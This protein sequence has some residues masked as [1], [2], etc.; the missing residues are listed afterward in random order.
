MT[1]EQIDTLGG[2]L[3]AALCAILSPYLDLL[4]EPTRTNAGTFVDVEAQL[5]IEAFL[6]KI[7]S[8]ELK[9]KG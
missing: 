3:K 6:D 1:P 8:G 2:D 5:T 4:D 9:E 7:A